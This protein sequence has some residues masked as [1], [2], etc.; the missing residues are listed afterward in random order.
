ML[1]AMLTGKRAESHGEGRFARF[2][3]WVTDGYG[4]LLELALRHRLA[5]IGTFIFL[6]VGAVVLFPYL[7]SEFLPRMDDG[8][9]MVKVKLPTGAALTETTKILSR[10]EEKLAGD[11]L[12]ESYVTMA[13]GKV[14][15]LATYEIANE[16]QVDIQLV[17]RHARK[18][19]TKAYMERLKKTLAPV[20]IPGAK[21]M[22]MQMPVKGIR[23]LGEADIEVKI[24]GQEMDKLFDLARQTVGVHE[25]AGPFHQCL[26]VHGHD[27]ARV[28]GGGGPGPGR[29]TGNL[30]S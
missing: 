24:K 5:V 13:G 1:T 27:Q 15:G 25:Q 26:C 10:V 20:S 3:A 14:W 11:P 7:G 6:L 30:G 2:F 19:G 17:P 21:P 29:R 18:I 4:R 12:V 8:R 28:P 22:V 23:K 16:G 9:V